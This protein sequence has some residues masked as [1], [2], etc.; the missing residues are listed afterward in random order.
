M[1]RL[2]ARTPF[3]APPRRT[4]T[5]PSLPA[6]GGGSTT[7]T[8]VTIHRARMHLGRRRAVT[9]RA[10]AIR[11][12]GEFTSSGAANTPLP[13]TGDALTTQNGVELATQGGEVIETQ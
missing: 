3:R 13:P 4:R 1:A 5:A 9:P 10:Y 7:T 8:T 12:L 6:G 11:H 2:S